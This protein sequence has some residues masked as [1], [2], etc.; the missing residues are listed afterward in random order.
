M[1]PKWPVDMGVRKKVEDGKLRARGL[2][3]TI[4]NAALYCAGLLG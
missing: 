4:S 2:K 1:R 3:N